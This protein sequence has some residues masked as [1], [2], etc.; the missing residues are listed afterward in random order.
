MYYCVRSHIFMCYGIHKFD[1]QHGLTLLVFQ[2]LRYLCLASVLGYVMYST[3]NVLLWD[4]VPCE[5]DALAMSLMLGR[6]LCVG[7]D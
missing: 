4:P 3:L 6:L 7:F 2:M 5:V 1:D